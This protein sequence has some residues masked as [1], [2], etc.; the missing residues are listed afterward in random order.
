MPRPKIHA[1]KRDE[2]LAK[3]IGI[4]LIPADINWLAET[5]AQMTRSEQIRCAI[6]DAKCWRNHLKEVR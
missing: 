1:D 3:G 5:Y 4:S 2:Q 6:M